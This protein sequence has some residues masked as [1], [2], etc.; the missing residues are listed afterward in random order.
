MTDI[1]IFI[2]ILFNDN[3]G[4]SY[5]YIPLHSSFRREIYNKFKMCIN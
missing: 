3:E 5:S 1:N 2:V 4:K